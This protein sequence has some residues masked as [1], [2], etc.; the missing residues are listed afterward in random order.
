MREQA[1]V[2]EDVDDTGEGR[3]GVIEE[4][5]FGRDGKGC[6]AKIME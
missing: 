3:E 1:F 6:C 2:G 4:L 5:H